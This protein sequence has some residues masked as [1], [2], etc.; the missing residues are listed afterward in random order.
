MVLRRVRAVRVRGG[1]RNRTFK[2]VQRRRS[3]ERLQRRQ[4]QV[5]YL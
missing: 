1:S 2:Y 5:R 4:W 3:Q